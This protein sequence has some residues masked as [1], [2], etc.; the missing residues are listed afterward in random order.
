MSEQSIINGGDTSW[1][2]ASACL[3]M[4]MT[5]GLGFFYGGMVNNKNLLSTIAYCYISFAVITLVWY[6]IGFSLVFGT[7]LNSAGFLG[8]LSLGALDFD[9]K[10][11][12]PFYGTTIPAIV[13][14]FFQIKFATITPAL[15]AGAVVERMRLSRYL[16]FVVIWSLCIYCPVGHWVWNV[17]GWGFKLGAIDFAGGFVVHMTS[18]FSAL[19]AALVVGKRRKLNKTPCNVPLILLGTTFL[20]F[21]WFGFNGGSSLKADSVAASACVVTNMAGATAGLMWLFVDYLYDKKISIVGFCAGAVCGLVGITPASGYVDVWAGIIIGIFSGMF[22]N[23]FCRYKN[24][25]DL[26]DDALDA[27]G[28]HG[29][30]GTIGSILTAFFASNAVNPAGPNGVFYGGAD[31]LWKQLVVS[32]VVAAWS[33][34]LSLLILLIMKKTMGLRVNEEEEIMGLDKVTFG[35]EAMNFSIFED[36]K[37]IKNE[38][39][40]AP[41]N[42]NKKID[43]TEK[44]EI[45]DPYN[46]RTLSCV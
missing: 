24:K 4:I 12:S 37:K 16:F 42:T 8:D 46:V 3:V 11:P 2:L 1:V 10:S 19:A 40:I 21:G 44:V 22:S 43:S 41:L 29:V 39:E 5:P 15:I 30:S 25:Y 45:V 9:W 18:G 32:L 31:L 13:F 14:F 38:Y 27:F 6:F 7:S 33:F 23:I 34:F 26:F 20:W 36:F 17:E 35:E 28:C